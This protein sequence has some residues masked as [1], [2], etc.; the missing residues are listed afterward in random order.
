MMIKYLRLI[1]LSVFIGVLGVISSVYAQDVEYTPEQGLEFFN[2]HNYKEAEQIYHKLLEKYPKDARYNY[3]MG[4]CELINRSNLSGA[5]KKLNYAAIKNVSRDAYFYLGRAHHLSYHFEEAISNY[6]KFKQYASKDDLRGEK[7]DLYIT[8]C[9]DG[10]RISSKIYNL[11]VLDKTIVNKSKLLDEYKPAKDVGKLYKN[12]D[13]F[14]SGV[15]PGHIMFETERGDVVYFSMEASSEDTLNIY[16]MVKLIDG[17]GDSE[18]VGEPVN[19][20]YNDAYPF[21]QTDGVTFYFASD[22]PGGFGGFDIYKA[23]YDNETHSF[24]EPINLGVPFNSPD[25]DFLF[26]SDEFNQEAWFASTRE[27]SNDEVMVYTIRWDGTQVRNM[28]EEDGEIL[29]SAMLRVAGEDS[30]NETEENDFAHTSSVKKKQEKALFHF[31]INDTISYSQY[32]HFIDSEAQGLFKSGF[33]LE[34]QK[35]SLSLLM[36]GKRRDYSVVDDATQRN[37]IVNDILRLENQVYSLDDQIQEKYLYAR[38][39]ELNEIVSQVNKGVYQSSRQVQTDK[40]TELSIEGV[41]IPERYT[42]YSSDEFE[43][44]YAKYDKMYKQL[45]SENDI[46]SLK[47]ADSLYVWANILNLESSQLLAKS[48]QV[49][50]EHSLKL[51]ALTK[52]KDSLK[53]QE[54]ESTASTMIK[55][56][57]E[58]KILSTRIYH[59]AMDK[60]Y[61]IYWLKL[62]DISSKLNDEKGSEVD[63][64]IYQ[65]NAYFREAKNLLSSLNALNIESFEKAG[66]MKKAGIES[67]ENALGLYCSLLNEGYLPEKQQK[68]DPKEE[69]QKSAVGL[70]KAEEGIQKKSEAE[71]QLVKKDDTKA[72]QIDNAEEYRIQIGVFRNSPNPDALAKIPAV[73]SIVI[74][75]RGLTKYFAGHYASK[76]EALQAIP[77]VIEAGFSGAFVV[78]FKQGKISSLPQK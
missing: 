30:D 9:N 75:G 37:K 23:F 13:F 3:Y 26:V 41:F 57:K 21:L 12:G 63:E 22:R 54:E 32:D 62:K 38:Q 51:S 55:D 17:W 39:K 6:K 66:A 40:P 44:Q 70:D 78:Y 19:S 56:S 68:D 45:F 53:S 58:L 20:L 10:R 71:V 36:K 5:I 11:E 72:V 4:I 15:N 60:K 31:E 33:K 2:A 16:K 50:E 61:P 34:Q 43:R 77:Q 65:G 67:Q 73:S 27:T 46:K 49:E 24:L 35:D 18:S 59:K 42:M 14:A 48:N 1:Y 7:A 69:V 28:V 74:E 64:L 29:Q 8:Q 25:D 76:E 52:G 47:Y